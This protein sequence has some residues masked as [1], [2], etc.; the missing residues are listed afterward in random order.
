MR[1]GCRMRCGVSGGKENG[2]EKGREGRKLAL[3][4]SSSGGGW[5][6]T[7]FSVRAMDM[8]EFSPSSFFK[9][10][11]FLRLAVCKPVDWSE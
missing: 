11:E 6:M 5:R 1:A 4:F 8:V 10:R 2:W 9:L 7:P 3:N